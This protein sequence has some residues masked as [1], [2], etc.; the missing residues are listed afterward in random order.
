MR[1]LINVPN[2]YLCKAISGEIGYIADG[3]IALSVEKKEED[4]L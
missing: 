2:S 4:T 1:W 3:L